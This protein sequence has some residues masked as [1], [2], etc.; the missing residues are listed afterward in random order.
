MQ[1]VFL[2][3]HLWCTTHFQARE[4]L[5]RFP[6]IRA[7]MRCLL[8]IEA[9]EEDEEEEEDSQ[10]EG[11]V[12]GEG[13]DKG[14]PPVLISTTEDVMVHVGCDGEVE[15]LTLDGLQVAP[16]LVGPGLAQAFPHLKALSLQEVG[17]TSQDLSGLSHMVHH[18]PALRALWLNDNPLMDHLDSSAL[19]QLGAQRLEIFN[20]HLTP[21]YSQWA[22]LYLASATSPQDV[23][24]LDLSHRGLESLKPQTFQGFTN[25]ES[26]DLRHNPLAPLSLAND[27]VPTL[28]HLPALTHLKIDTPSTEWDLQLLQ[29]FPH[30]QYLNGR[31]VKRGEDG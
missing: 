30:L 4:Q 26:L 27:L 18:L 6:T 11:Q 10:V 15:D 25:L 29:S 9:P 17:L 16:G 1:A 22:L 24:A 23:T 2:V 14:S 28:K 7:N 5:E 12:D 20:R 19:T 3:D 21:N 8:D 13:T 31:A